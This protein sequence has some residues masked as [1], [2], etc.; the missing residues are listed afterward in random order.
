VHPDGS[1][2]VCAFG[3][4]LQLFSVR[5]TLAAE[6]TAPACSL[7]PKE[8]PSGVSLSGIADTKCISF[9]A[10]GSRMVLGAGDGRLRMFSW[11]ELALRADVEHAHPEA[12]SDADFSP[13]GSLLLTTGNERVG[14]TGGATVWRVAE[15][16]LQRVCWLDGVP[17]PKGAR[18]TLRGAKFARDGSG[19]AFTGANLR[20]E[21][22]VLTW[23]TSD[24]RCVASRRALTEPLTSLALSPG[25]GR[26]LAAG[27]SEGSIVMIASKTLAPM[28][29]VPS[30]HMVFVTGLSFSPSGRTLASLSADASARCTLAP[31]KRSVLAA[32]LRL[33]LALL[34]HMAVVTLVITTHRRGMWNVPDWLRALRM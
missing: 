24:W 6:G 21:S 19:T 1:T 8:L 20:E 33:L 27:G 14:P 17:A 23:R 11:P 5:V 28:R 29:R 25:N 32:L 7:T 10:D 16:A 31:P 18:V 26:L 30:A 3:D 9:S 4:R 34:V 2:L 13:D 22:R 15:S 12:V